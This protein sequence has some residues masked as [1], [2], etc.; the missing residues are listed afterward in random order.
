M[1]NQLSIFFVLSL[2]C[3]S[4]VFAQESEEE[5]AEISKVEALLN[6]VK[7]GKTDEQSENAKREARF[8]ANKNK[9]AEILAAEKRELAR[10]EKIADSFESEYKK[11]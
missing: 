8:M 2:S 5:T 6:L 11:N 9:Q 3:I 10:Q 4:L 7:Q 1:K